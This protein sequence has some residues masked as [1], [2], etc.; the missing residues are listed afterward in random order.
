MSLMS[1]STAGGGRHLSGQ[2]KSANLARNLRALEPEDAED[3][4][5]KIYI[6]VTE[7]LRRLSTQVKVLLDIA[8]SLADTPEGEGVKSPTMRS[9]L[10]SP[11]TGQAPSPGVEIQEELHKALDVTHLLAQGVDIANDKIVKV[12]KVRTE[13]ATDLPLDMFLRYFTLNLYFAN[14]CEAISGRSGTSLK[15]VVNSHIKEFVQ[16]HQNAAMQTLAQGMEA[17][18][19]VAKDFNEKLTRQLGEILECSTH[20]AESWGNGSKLWV[21]AMELLKLKLEEEA[22]AEKDKERSSSEKEKARPA[23]IESEKFI[24]PNSALLCMQGLEGFLHLIAGIPSMATDIATSLI[25]YL[26]LFNS[27]CTQLILGAGATKTAGLRNITTKHLSLASRA[28]GLIATLIPHIREFVR[29]H[30]GSGAGTSALMGEF[31][32]IRRLLQEHQS[33]IHQK[34]VEMMNGRATVHSKGMKAIEW[35]KDGASARTHGYMETL[36]KETSTLYKVLTKHLPDSTTQSIMFPVFSGYKEQ[37]GSAF[38]DADAKNKA[39]QQSM[40]RDIALFKSTLGSIEGFGDAGE[41]L[42][43]IVN[44]KEVAAEAEASAVDAAK[45][46]TLGDKAKQD[47]ANGE[48]EGKTDKAEDEDAATKDEKTESGEEEKPPEPP[49]KDNVAVNGKTDSVRSM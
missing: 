22:A 31:D 36:V 11:Q 18:R 14:E 46:A 20:D 17:D 42:T 28:L 41:Y 15:N 39:G 37:L 33:N 8:S 10:G 30:A 38:K 49:A 6:S 16:R 43:N 12:L 2:E 24:L 27:R 44:S 3:L 9:P 29:R 25:A 4:L 13:Q 7:A 45:D 1:V 47:N 32:K 5:K 23:V 35:H 19:W 40:L 26:Q 48:D 34:L 21:P